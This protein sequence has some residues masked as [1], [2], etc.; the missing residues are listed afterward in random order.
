MMLMFQLIVQENSCDEDM[1]VGQ[2]HYLNL[3]QAKL[4]DKILPE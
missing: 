4:G 2:D 3:N 1:F